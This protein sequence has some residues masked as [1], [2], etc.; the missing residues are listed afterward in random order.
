MISAGS[1]TTSRDPLFVAY[2]DALRRRRRAPSTLVCNTHALRKLDLWLVARGIRAADMRPL[3]YEL[4]FEEQLGRYAIST[5]HHDLSIVRA[6]CRYGARH[7][8]LEGDPTLDVKL[9]RVPDIEPATY[10][11]DELRAI[12]A[13][14][15]Q[16]PRESNT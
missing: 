9:P 6:A 3:D 11:N 2:L 16:D 15:R 1:A 12:L 4:Y 10:S 8:L 14:V 13:A 5:L 7:D